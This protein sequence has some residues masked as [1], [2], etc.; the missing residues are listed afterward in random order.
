LRLV[1]QESFPEI[2]RKYIY[3]AWGDGRAVDLLF[4]AKKTVGIPGHLPVTAKLSRFH[5]RRAKGF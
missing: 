3:A 5:T 4:L 1:T 2:L